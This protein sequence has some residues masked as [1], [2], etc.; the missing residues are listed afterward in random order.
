MILRNVAPRCYERE[1]RSSQ[2]VRW[3]SVYRILLGRG[4]RVELKINTV[5]RRTCNSSFL[6]P[7]QNTVTT[8]THRQK[9]KTG[10]TATV[11]FSG[12]DGLHGQ[13]NASGPTPFIRCGISKWSLTLL[14]AAFGPW[15]F[16]DSTANVDNI[17]R[18]QRQRTAIPT[19]G[20]KVVETWRHEVGFRTPLSVTRRLIKTN[21]LMGAVTEN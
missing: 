17:G 18:S 20:A 4:G 6:Y 8:V 14:W 19:R 10:R 3:L 12:R 15:H 21:E 7:I 1:L 16:R 13:Q 11:N 2:T 5:Y 9:Q